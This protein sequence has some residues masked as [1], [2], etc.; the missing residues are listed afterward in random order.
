MGPIKLPNEE[1]IR[2][3]YRQGEDAMVGLVSS[4]IRIVQAP[5]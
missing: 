2:A 4:L 3:I 5:S 1:G